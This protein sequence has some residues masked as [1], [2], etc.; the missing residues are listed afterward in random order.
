MDSLVFSQKCTCYTDRISV[1]AI[2]NLRITASLSPR[3]TITST[4]TLSLEQPFLD[5][6]IEFNIRKV[7]AP[8]YP[9]W[10]I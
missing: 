6:G 5:Y 1:K 4:T 2:F 3:K 10:V 8:F 9:V 7:L